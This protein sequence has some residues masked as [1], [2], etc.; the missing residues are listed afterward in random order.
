YA[1]GD[2]LR[3]GV[4]IGIGEDDVRRFSSEFERGGDDV[5]CRTLRDE[6]AYWI[7]PHESDVVEVRMLAQSLARLGADARDHIDDSCRESGLACEFGQTDGSPRRLV[8]GLE[9]NRV[10]RHDGWSHGAAEELHRIV[11]RDDAPADSERL[12]PGER[13]EGLVDGK[14]FTVVGLDGPPVELEVPGCDDRVVSCLRQRLSGVLRLE[15][16]EFIDLA[17]NAFGERMH[18]VRTQLGL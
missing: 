15:F 11:P 10:S 1:F 9:D 6:P 12:T 14:V 8:G 4:E 18:E 7:G 17:Q 5:A 2:E 16:R 3:S 13:V